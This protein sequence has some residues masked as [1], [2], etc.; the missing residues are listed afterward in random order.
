MDRH[1][2]ETTISKSTSR[3]N[4]GSSQFHKVVYRLQL[5]LYT[6]IRV[7]PKPNSVDDADR[8]YTVL[9]TSTTGPDPNERMVPCDFSTNGIPV[10]T[11]CFRVFER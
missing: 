10:I 9:L 11:V 7:K 6:S 2:R 8:K 4:D 5:P 1:S 3:N